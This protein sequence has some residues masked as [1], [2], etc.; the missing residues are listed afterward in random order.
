MMDRDD[1]LP[2]AFAA[3]VI[4]AGVSYALHQTALAQGLATLGWLLL[5]L[6]VIGGLLRGKASGEPGHDE[7]QK[8]RGRFASLDDEEA[9][10]MDR[11][12]RK[13]RHAPQEPPG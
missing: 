7:A 8:G 6:A 9:Q 5:L 2:A 11:V 12:L 3:L 1:I 13:E 4:L 10:R